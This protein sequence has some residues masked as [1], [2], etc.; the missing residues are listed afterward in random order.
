MVLSYKEQS[1]ERIIKNSS[2]RGAAISQQ[3]SDTDCNQKTKDRL[4]SCKAQF[5]HTLKTKQ[6]NIYSRIET[7]FELMNRI[8]LV[9]QH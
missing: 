1:I 8:K 9:L 6:R 2:S 4:F 3:S 5:S 7:R